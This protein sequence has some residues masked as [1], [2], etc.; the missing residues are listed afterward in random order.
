MKPATIVKASGRVDSSA[1]RPERMRVWD[2]LTR[3]RRRTTA[4]MP[5]RAGGR[6][7][8]ERRGIERALSMISPKLIPV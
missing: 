2:R 1:T 3:G 6:E 7:R 4:R 5:A 8:G